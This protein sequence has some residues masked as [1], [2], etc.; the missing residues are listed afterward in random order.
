MS[1]ET[2]NN[3][4]ETNAVSIDDVPYLLVFGNKVSAPDKKIDELVLRQGGDVAFSDGTHQYKFILKGI[5]F[6]RK[7]YQPG[8]ILAELVVE[9]PQTRTPSLKTIADLF[10]QRMVTLEEFMYDDSETDMKMMM[11]GKSQYKADEVNKIKIS[12]VVA[13]NYYVYEANPQL[14]HGDNGYVINMKLSI[15]SMDKLMTLNKYS[16]AY[17]N[18]KLG[19]GILMPE[20]RE[21]GL[22]GTGTKKDPLIQ[23]NIGAICFLKYPEQLEI[24]VRRATPDSDG[25]MEQKYTATVDAEFIHPYLVQYNETFYDFMARTANRCGE[26]LYFEDG[27]LTLGLPNSGEAVKITDFKSLTFQEVV[28]GPLEISGYARDSVKDGVGKVENLNQTA[29]EK[30]P[31]KYPSDAFASSTAYNSELAVDEYMFPLCK[32]KF[33]STNYE[34]RC[35]GNASQIAMAN[36]IPFFRDVLTNEM[37]GAKGLG[38]AVAKTLAIQ[39]GIKRGLSWNKGRTINNEKNTL[40]LTPYEKKPEQSDGTVTVQYGT[41]SEKGWT[42]LNYFNDVR[43]H[44]EKQQRQTI[45]I[46]LGTDATHYKLGQKIKVKGCEGDYVI[47]EIQKRSGQNWDHDYNKYDQ[48][49]SDKVSGIRSQVIYAIPA[50]KGKDGK[51]Q[52]IPPVSNQ[53]IIR[54]V[55]P[56]T[57]FIVDNGDPKQQGR[58]RIAYPWQ[59]LANAKRAKM[60]ETEEMLKQIE[61]EEEENEAK[62]NDVNEAHSDISSYFN[63]HDF[64]SENCQ[65]LKTEILEKYKQCQKK[66]DGCKKGVLPERELNGFM[67]QISGLP[68]EKKKE[69]QNSIARE[70]IPG[71]EKKM[72]TLSEELEAIEKVIEAS[73][74]S[75]AKK[76]DEDKKGIL[77]KTLDDLEKKEGKRY[78][79]KDKELKQRKEEA[80]KEVANNAEK[81]QGSLEEIASPWIRVSTPMATTGGGAFFKPQVGD[82]VLINYD[83][84]NIDRPYVVGG[85]FSKNTLVPADGLAR[86]MQPDVQQ[87]NV[88]IALMSPNGHHITF[89]DPEYGGSFFTN[90]LSPGIGFYSFISGLDKFSKGSKDLGGVIHIG[91]RY[92]LY[93]IEMLSHKRSVRINSPFGTVEVNAFAGITINAPNGDVKIRGKNITLEAGNKVEIISG[94]NIQ[95]AGIGSPDTGQQKAR[96]YTLLAVE[97]IGGGAADMFVT[98]VADLSL[99]RHVMETFVR[100]V[101][102]TA[103]IKSKRFLKLEAGPGTANIRANRYAW[104][105]EES[106]EE[107]YKT[108]VQCVNYISAKI[109]QFYKEYEE[110]WNIAYEKKERYT[111]LAKMYISEGS[112]EDINIPEL[113]YDHHKDLVVEN[114]DKE[115]YKKFQND[116]EDYFVDRFH[117]GDNLTHDRF[118][119]RSY[120]D[121]DGNK[122]LNGFKTKKKYELI[123]PQVEAYGI[124]CCDLYNHV[125]NFIEFMAP[126]DIHGKYE[127]ISRN[128][129][130]ITNHDRFKEGFDQWK[131]NFSK[132]RKKFL[133]DPVSDAKLDM[134]NKANRAYYKRLFIALFLDHLAKSSENKL[135]TISAKYMY[136]GADFKKIAGGDKMALRS[137]YWWKRHILAMDRWSQTRFLRDVFDLTVGK[138][139]GKLKTTFTSHDRAIW[140]DRADGQILFSDKE[141]ATLAFENGGVTQYDDA[142]VGTMDYLKKILMAIK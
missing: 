105:K 74:Q 61:K 16:K 98:P 119:Q 30:T 113:V 96:D 84:D 80:Q 100:P 118:V 93:E 85:L 79:D 12:K 47:I 11:L 127:W 115:A 72:A 71:L 82:E 134:Y 132:G 90:A 75:N 77:S 129:F 78:E 139:L 33:S 104:D 59:S 3:N 124:A 8:E 27:K 83:N 126:L 48:Q 122:V 20:S 5:K 9:I 92:G 32:D 112:L 125:D 22:V 46:D 133:A 45:C 37:A 57:A 15:F 51:D 67:D 110:L 137:D 26:F 54:K 55:G 117:N 2:N 130:D 39:Q 36:L 18:K 17:V 121:A 66:I 86:Y 40:F 94:K 64:S 91:D 1:N 107:F 89:T 52:F 131:D 25:N 136:V 6:N 97:G 87:R 24:K 41:L 70:S 69:L 49:A 102:G 95:P 73:V 108:V 19:S 99:V 63:S 103:L 44:Q 56:Q 13:E 101:D 43:R 14:V 31:D 28:P 128:F 109:D 76:T 7:I 10:A 88:N 111:Q 23:T 140:R 42:T 81:A 29:I 114:R 138:I 4:Q 62:H 141:N 123:R 106:S 65:K 38:I 50:Y 53:P 21:F 142:N 60:F 34:M 120:K 116:L 68:V 135:G 35:E 58:V